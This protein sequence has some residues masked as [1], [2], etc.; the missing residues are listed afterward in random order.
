MGALSEYAKLARSFN[1]AL[2]AVGPPLGAIASGGSESWEL[3]LLFLLGA[4]AHIFGFVLNDVIDLPIDDRSQELRDRPLLSGSISRRNAT[5]FAFGGLGV[6]WIAAI[7]LTG[8]WHWSL[9]LLAAATLG[10]T[11][12]NLASKVV[13]GM[14]VFVAG[15]IFFLIMFGASFRLADPVLLTPLA[16][17]VAL[18]GF[19]QVLFMNIVAGG[20][21][22]IDHDSQAGGTTLA[23]TLGCHVAPD[24]ALRIPFRFQALAHGLE[25]LHLTLIAAA[26][27][28]LAHSTEPLTGAVVGVEALLAVAMLRTS[29]A[30]LGMERWDRDALRARIGTHYLLN[31]SLVPVMLALIQPWALFLLLVPPLGFIGSNLALHGT[32]LAPRTM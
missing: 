30:L 5:A 26:T 17:L 8:G 14:D 2:T 21:K 9:L 20:L 15:A 13:P 6:M 32:L 16:V 29:S 23:W 12:Y 31:Y 19:G 28:M 7:A 10:A 24:G 27:W 1:L 4:G 11:V 18:L 3:V 25:L 22:D